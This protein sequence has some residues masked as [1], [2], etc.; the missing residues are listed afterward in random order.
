MLERDLEA[1]IVSHCK[2]RGLLIYKFS[3]PSN[4]GVPDRIIVGM[5]KVMFLEIKS[6]KGRLTA[7]QERE[8]ARLREAGV[9]AEAVNDYQ[10]AV[11]LIDDFFGAGEDVI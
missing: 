5:G 7:L 6:A 11:E 1:K 2:Q 4:R 3:S 9:R 8:L 10:I